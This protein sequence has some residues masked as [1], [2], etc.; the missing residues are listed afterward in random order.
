MNNIETKTTVAPEVGVST[1]NENEVKMFSE[2]IAAVRAELAK[3]VVMSDN[4][5]AAMSS[6]KGNINNST[7]SS[8]ILPLN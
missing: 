8:K 7:S 6:A 5:I 1:S 3:D 4:I 2:K